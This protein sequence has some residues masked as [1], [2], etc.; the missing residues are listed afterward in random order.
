MFLTKPPAFQ[1]LGP[2]LRE[3][4]EA[5]GLTLEEASSSAGLQAAEVSALEEGQP[6][7]AG[8]ARLQAVSYARSLSLDVVALRDSLPAQPPLVSTKQTYLSNMSRPLRP[9]FRFSMELLAPL[10]PLGRAAVYLFLIAT[11]FS[12]WEMMRQL[13][14]VRSIP[15]ITSNNQLTTFPV[16]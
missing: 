16:R 1:P 9:R 8:V 12:T 15:W 13:S 3:A 6:L 2:L 4:R 10:A 7:E 11:F 14:R 5:R